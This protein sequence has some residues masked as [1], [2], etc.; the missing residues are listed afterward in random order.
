[1]DP[2]DRLILALSA[3]LRAERETRYSFEACIAA[4]TLDSE[5]LQAIISD[6]VPTVTREDLNFAEEVATNINSFRGAR[7]S[8]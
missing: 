8:V 3:L 5:T 1:M 7:L 2:R 6:P 4:G